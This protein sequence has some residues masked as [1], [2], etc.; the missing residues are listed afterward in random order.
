M[1]AAIVDGTIF[2][3]EAERGRSGQLKTAVRRLRHV[4][5]TLLGAV[6]AKFDPAKA[7]NRY[8]TYS[9]YDYYQY[10]GAKAVEGPGP[11]I[12]RPRQPA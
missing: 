1:I 11:A 6:L 8:S 9:G 7:G 5:P 2:V 12:E 3:V 10:A 4:Q